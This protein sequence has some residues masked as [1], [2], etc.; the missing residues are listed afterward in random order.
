[1]EEP[2]EKRQRTEEPEGETKEDAPEGEKTE[3]MEESKPTEEEAKAPEPAKELETDAPEDSRKKVK[4]TIQFLPHDTTINVLPSTHSNLLISMKEGGI[5][6][7]HAG[8]RANIGLTGGRYYFECK[9]IELTHSQEQS[10][11][12]RRPRPEYFVKLGLA[13]AD[14]S[15][16][17]GGCPNSISI[18]TDGN[19]IHNRTRSQE[20]QKVYKDSVMGFLINL[21]PVSPNANTISQFK[22]GVRSSQPIKIPENMLGKPLYP[23]VSFKNAT[24]QLN[25]GPTSMAPL[26]FKCPMVQEAAADDAKITPAPKAA[27]PE[28]FVPV[29][30]PDEGT[31]DWADV[32][33]SKNPT[34]TELSDRM[35]L[36]WA[37]KSGIWRPRHK[38]SND[39][40]E[41]QFQV[42]ELDD[43]SM[44]RAIYSIA[45]LQNRSFLVMEVKSNL[46]ADERQNLLAKF[47][48]TFKKTALVVMGTPK[49]DFKEHTKSLLLKQKQEALDKAHEAKKMELARKKLNEQRLKVQAAAAA[50]ATNG[51]EPA[52][53][54]EDAKMESKE[55]EPKAEEKEAEAKEA[56]EEAPK[57]ELTP[58]EE[59]VRF[60][61]HEIKDLTGPMLTINFPKFSMPTKDEGFDDIKYEWDNAKKSEEYLNEYISDKKLHLRVDDLRPGLWFEKQSRDWYT[62]LHGW[63]HTLADYE[64]KMAQKKAK[65]ALKKQAELAAKRAAEEKQGEAQPM[66]TDAEKEKKE[67]EEET[68]EPA[69]EEKK[70]E[71]EATAEGDEEKKEEEKKEEEKKEEEEEEED[72]EAM[73]A[74]FEALDVFGVENVSDIGK[75]VPLYKDFKFEDWILMNLRFELH[76]MVHAFKKD[77]EDKDR[78]GIHVENL[79]FYYNRYFKKVLSFKEYGV[80]T[81]EELFDLISDAV[82][83]T[84]KSVITSR[85][86]DEMEAPLV[87]VKITEE[88]RRFRTLK[89]DLGEEAQFGVKLNVAAL[90]AISKNALPR[91][92]GGGGGGHFHKGYHQKGGQP[93]HQSYKGGPQGYQK[94]G[95]GYK[96]GYG[97]DQGKDHGKDH[98]KDFGKDFG[99]DHGKDSWGKGG[100]KVGAA[101]GKGNVVPPPPGPPPAAGHAAA[102]GPLVP[103]PPPSSRPAP[104]AAVGGYGKASYGSKGKP[105]VG[106]QPYGGGKGF[107]GGSHNDYG[108]GGYQGKW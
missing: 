75:G 98:G 35:I 60:C 53:E 26:P 58:E 81:A 15:L 37:E 30:L 87:F 51:D 42:P 88:A 13:T 40:P 105:A 29:C 19:I 90:T 97:K 41:M 71:E 101:P 65:A 22:D 6:H 5:Q 17:L 78:E 96:G 33:L 44:R 52:K 24:V 86:S 20:A 25:F 23:S 14:S 66:E 69:D 45:P 73:E 47:P 84:P 85:L 67:G 79:L 63:H 4:E 38:S 28:L 27:K 77:V 56:E 76:T 61:S 10:H 100:H 1:M 107:K 62:T 9:V 59:Q 2:A 55:D 94:G 64:S 34:V 48:S 83:L 72:E 36:E 102:G 18:D 31:F 8:A 104:E 50:A 92:L 16:V 99:K 74:A 32:W 108:K 68:K 46:L 93:Y 39:K 12:T 70:A 49:A 7:F 103:P 3:Q 106:Y 82:Y 89:V 54:G 11:A 95:Y 21:D 80:E 91:R 43:Y 57:A